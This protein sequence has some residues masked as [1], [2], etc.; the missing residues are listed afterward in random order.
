MAAGECR[1]R[2]PKTREKEKKVCDQRYVDSKLVRLRTGYFQ[3]LC[4]SVRSEVYSMVESEPRNDSPPLSAHLNLESEKEW[5]FLFGEFSN[6]TFTFSLSS[7]SFSFKVRFV[8]YV[9]K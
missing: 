8:K 7:K 1:C 9:I 4:H 3:R 6:C 2:P 5:P